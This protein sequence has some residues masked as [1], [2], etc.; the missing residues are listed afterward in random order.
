MYKK[1]AIL[2]HPPFEYDS[3]IKQ[4]DRIFVSKGCRLLYLLKEGKAFRRYPI[5]LGFNPVGSKL[6]EGDGRTPEG[7]YIIDYHNPQ[8]RYFLSL[9]ISYPNLEDKMRANELELTPGFDIMVHGTN[10]DKLGVKD[11]T[12]G[13]I[14]VE[15]SFMQEIFELVAD[16]TPIW[17]QA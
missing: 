3:S 5:E 9:H 8:S 1:C 2:P 7:D 13:C 16:G 15:N 17:I 12:H 14:A 10:E 4:A 6:R 11:W